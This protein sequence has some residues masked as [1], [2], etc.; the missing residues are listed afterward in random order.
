LSLTLSG[1]GSSHFTLYFT[2]GFSGALL[3]GEAGEKDIPCPAT[4]TCESTLS[5]LFCSGLSLCDLPA[6]IAPDLAFLTGS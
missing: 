5:R 2:L 6:E 4:C 1:I 3:A